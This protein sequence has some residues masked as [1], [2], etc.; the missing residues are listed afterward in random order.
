MMITPP[1]GLTLRIVDVTTCATQ[2]ALKQRS[3]SCQA[4]PLVYL[5]QLFGA[6]KHIIYR[7]DV[8]V[9]SDRLVDSIASRHG[10]IKQMTNSGKARYTKIYLT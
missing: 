6:N 9:R 5:E 4:R 8:Q 1:S 2:K 7:K 3:Q 10:Y